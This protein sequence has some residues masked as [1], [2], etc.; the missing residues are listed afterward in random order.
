MKFA[1]S[2]SQLQEP[3]RPGVTRKASPSCHPSVG[4][5]CSLLLHHSPQGTA[6]V[7]DE[8]LVRFDCR[9][10]AGAGY[11]GEQQQNRIESEILARSQQ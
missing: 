3:I 11:T 1:V 4:I 5:F 8:K 10:T 2:T 9:S 6:V 7:G